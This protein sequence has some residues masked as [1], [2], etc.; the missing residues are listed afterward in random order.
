M[1]SEKKNE[2][3]AT[4]EKFIIESRQIIENR[5]P[6]PTEYT[7]GANQQD[8]QWLIY[9][10]LRCLRLEHLIVLRDLLTKTIEEE[11]KTNAK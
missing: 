10:H 8:S 1:F 7:I 4:V 11:T 5:V 9:G 6:R 2:E 3:K